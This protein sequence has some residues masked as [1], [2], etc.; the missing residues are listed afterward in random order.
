VS[1]TR[2]EA[3]EE[4]VRAGDVEQC[5]AFFE[6]MPEKERSKL[7]RTAARLVKED[8]LS[9]WRAITV[10]NLNDLPKQPRGRRKRD[11]P[12]ILCMY[13]A[14]WAT[15]SLGQLKRL[16]WE[17][18]PPLS[19]A[20]WQTP[21]LAIL[22]NRRPGWLRDLCKSLLETETNMWDFVRKMAREKLCEP[23]E[24]DMYVLG[25][26]SGIRD[27]RFDYRVLEGLRNDPELLDEMVW[28]LFKIP[29]DR[30]ANLAYLGDSTTEERN[31]SYAFREL[32]R[33]CAI[34]RQR[35]LDESLASLNLD[36]SK[37]HASWFSRFHEYME[38]TVEERSARVERYLDLLSSP[39]QPTVSMAVKALRTLHKAGLLDGVAFV[40]RAEPALYATTKTA[41]KSTLAILGGIASEQP[42]L[43]TEVAQLAAA[44]LEHKAAEVQRAALALVEKHGDRSDDALREAVEDRLPVMAVTTRKEAEVWL[45]AA[46][47]PTLRETDAGPKDH[48]VLVERAQALPSQISQATGVDA[49]LRELQDP[50]GA[51]RAVE[52]SSQTQKSSL[53]GI[54]GSVVKSLGARFGAI[55]DSGYLHGV[56][57]QWAVSENL[58]R[59]VLIEAQLGSTSPEAREKWA[60]STR[61][62]YTRDVFC[63]PRWIDR[64]RPTYEPQSAF[65]K[66]ALAPEAT[67]SPVGMIMLCL[68]LGAA[69]SEDGQCATDVLIH[70]VHDGQLDGTRLGH[71]MQLLLKVGLVKPNK[72]MPQLVKPNRWA[73]RLAV[74]AGESAL[75]GQV[76]RNALVRA[77]PGIPADGMRNIHTLLEPLFN[78]CVESEETIADPECR[79][80]LE[81]IGGTGKAAKLAKKL[82][83]LEPG[84]PL[85]HRRAAAITALRGR[86][87]RAEHWAGSPRE[88]N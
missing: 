24:S 12:A 27:R 85:P 17:A 34:D 83:A 41:T 64:P 8:N 26:I 82:L 65:F 37:Y 1:G 72:W 44:A 61:P 15:A 75:H 7:A 19:D 13:S 68:G 2:E 28:R 60:K 11:S 32:S 71:S 47:A 73:E 56:S 51:N 55:Q 69:D 30:R 62:P 48:A 77:L 18:K 36:F 4:V 76:V 29:G 43:A 59:D 20:D 33:E 78:L 54:I 46:A 70:A 31:W 21:V 42:E 3:L 88:A 66:D 9:A 49:T 35:L 6:D 67:L 50:Q 14:L 52:G 57:N 23:P 79:A 87:E 45:G 40:A 25:M 38:P 63:T 58:L 5:L 84:N 81:G 80:F 53:L 74:A 22:R 16:G 86:L 39:I 10:T